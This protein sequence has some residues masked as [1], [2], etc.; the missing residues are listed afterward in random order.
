MTGTDASKENFDEIYEARR[1]YLA[2]IPEMYHRA[3]EKA[4]E[5]RGYKDSVRA[6]CLDCQSLQR[7][8][9]QNCE[10]YTCPLWSVRPYR[11]RATSRVQKGASSE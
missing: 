6:N 5:G 8:E 2:N 4:W 10:I 1:R 11:K 7:N 9:I 3:F